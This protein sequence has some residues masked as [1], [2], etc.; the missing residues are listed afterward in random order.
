MGCRGLWESDCWPDS[1]V[2]VVVVGWFVAGCSCRGGVAGVVVSGRGVDGRLSES[3][4]DD[5]DEDDSD[6][7]AVRSLGGGG[8]WVT[9]GISESPRGVSGGGSSTCM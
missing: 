6:G 4:D 7:V 9:D 5:D 8:R 1:L 3:V 2:V